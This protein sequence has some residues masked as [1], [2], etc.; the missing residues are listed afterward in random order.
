MYVGTWA[1]KVRIPKS[2]QPVAGD[3][4]VMEAHYADDGSLEEITVEEWKK[5]IA[6][7]WELSLSEIKNEMRGGST[8]ESEGEDKVEVLR[9]D[10][11]A[12]QA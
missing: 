9:N 6:E 8:P 2:V 4:Q 3:E 5:R 1:K 7:E 11:E 10:D 12:E